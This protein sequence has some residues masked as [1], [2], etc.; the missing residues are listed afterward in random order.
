[1][2]LK[3]NKKQ[4]QVKF[5]NGSSELFVLILEYT[6]NIRKGSTFR[7]W[8]NQKYISII[9]SQSQIEY[10]GKM[11]IRLNTW[12]SALEVKQGDQ[13][14]SIIIKTITSSQK[15]KR[16]VTRRRPLCILIWIECSV[17]TLSL[18]WRRSDRKWWMKPYSIVARE[19]LKLSQSLKGTLLS[20]S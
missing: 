13:D 4:T 18:L 1:M 8:R 6:I 15:F 7:K 10:I 3:K 20:Q 2:I 14:F 19:T 5:Q 12:T 11:H 17:K 9:K 16:H